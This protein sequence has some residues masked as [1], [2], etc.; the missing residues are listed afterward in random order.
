MQTAQAGAANISAA[1][2]RK[3]IAEANADDAHL[4]DRAR[5]L[6]PRYELKRL[7][8]TPGKHNK[9]DFFVLDLTHDKH[10]APALL[11]YAMSAQAD[12]F[13]QLADDLFSKIQPYIK[14]INE[15]AATGDVEVLTD[16]EKSTDAELHVA[17]MQMF[18]DMPAGQ[19]QS[20]LLK[21]ILFRFATKTEVP[22]PAPKP[23]R[24][25]TRKKKDETATDKTSEK[26]A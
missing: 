24:K 26:A 13:K 9:C 1:V 25:Y 20:E 2:R 7:D 23:K 6:Y 17:G 5:G 10:A 14:E 4:D 22:E 21:E 19:Y 12:G 11:S 3:L 8:G 16:I 15:Q 18:L